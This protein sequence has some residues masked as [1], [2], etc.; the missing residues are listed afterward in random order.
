[1]R[2]LIR[3]VAHVRTEHAIEIPT[4]LN[5]DVV[6]AFGADGPYEPLGESVGLRRSDRGADDLD[7]LGPEDLVERT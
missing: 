3:V 7:A 5:E 1:M 6:Q 4:P 2:P